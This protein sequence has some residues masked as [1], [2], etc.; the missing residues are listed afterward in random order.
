ME[1]SN[2]YLRNSVS[3]LDRASIA[4]TDDGDL[5]FSSVLK[6]F[7]RP[8]Y[9]NEIARPEAYDEFITAYYGEAGYNLPLCLQHDCQQ[10]IGCVTKIERDE[11]QLTIEASVFKSCPKFDYIADLVRRG[12][13]GGVS[14]GSSA[15]GYT[16]EDGNFVVEKAQMCEVS[17][18]TVPAEIV[19]GVELQNTVVK[20]FDHPA[21]RDGFAGMLDEK[22]FNQNLN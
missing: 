5:R 1:Q 11:K 12:V 8:N 22:M 19:A 9:N 13:L 15:Y 7:N 16:D 20:G 14:D 21:P 3:L 4:A 17:L 6:V 10:I 18:V 2:T